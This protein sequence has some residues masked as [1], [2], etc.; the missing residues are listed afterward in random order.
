MMLHL[1][2]NTK[3]KKAAQSALERNLKS[4]LDRQGTRK[5]GFPGGNVDQAVFSAGEGKL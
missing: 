2:E 3:D 5:I 4:A 1:V